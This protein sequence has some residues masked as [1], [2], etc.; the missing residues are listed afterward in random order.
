MSSS[1]CF[2]AVLQMIDTSVARASRSLHRW[3]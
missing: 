1:G 3:H 2:L